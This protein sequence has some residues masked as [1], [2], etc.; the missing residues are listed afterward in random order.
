RFWQ[1]WSREYV[2][3]LQAIIKWHKEEALVVVAEDNLPPQQCPSALTARS[4]WRT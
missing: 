4:E 3:S 2:S 1:P